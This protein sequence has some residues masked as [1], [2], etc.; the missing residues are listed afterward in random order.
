MMVILQVHKDNFG[1]KVRGR[2]RGMGL[3][4]DGLAEKA[5]IGKAMM[6]KIESGHLPSASALCKLAETLHCKFLF[7]GN[8]E[9][10]E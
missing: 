1:E 6:R 8:Y 9:V 10:K 7:E 5:G 4:V 3:S 2:R